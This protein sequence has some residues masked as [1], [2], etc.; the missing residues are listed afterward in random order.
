MQVAGYEDLVE[1]GRG[2]SAVVYRAR[3]VALDRTVALKVLAGTLGDDERRRFRRECT[4]IAALGWHPRVVAV[5]DA[6]VSDE[7]HPWMA[8]EYLPGGSLA[9]RVK[10]EGPLSA[11]EVAAI[12]I[13]AADALDA[14]HR[15]RIVHRDVKPGN[16]LQGHV[17]DV[18]LADFGIAALDSTNTSVTASFGGTLA[19]MAPELFAGERATTASD[20]YAL[21]ATLFVL[22]SGRPPFLAETPMAIL[23]HVAHDPVPD[24]RPLGV[25]APLAA[26]VEQAMAKDPADRPPSAA[27]TV[28]ALQA[29]A[30]EQGWPVEPTYTDRGS[31]PTQPTQP[32]QTADPRS[33]ALTGARRF[34]EPTGQGDQPTVLRASA[35]DPPAAHAEGPSPTGASEGSP[36]RRGRRIAAAAVAAILIVVGIAAAAITWL[37]STGTFVAFEGDQVAIYGGRPDGLLWVEPELLETTDV[38]R[39]DLPVDVR[40]VI[41]ASKSFSSRSAATRFVVTLQSIADEASSTSTPAPAPGT[42]STTSIDPL[43]VDVP[44]VLLNGGASTASFEQFA[45]FFEATSSELETGEAPTRAETTIYASTEFEDDAVALAEMLG[46]NPERVKPLT[47]EVEADLGRSGPVILVVGRDAPPP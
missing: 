45:T 13:Q 18:K 10:D 24:L 21:G 36:S 40:R 11:I 20:L 8:M 31:Q 43:Q 16:L 28:A 32:A 4:A 19:F 7:G 1:I 42:A 39:S 26:V 35:P 12:G 5:H 37:G 29:V 25:P 2:A 23:G 17:G 34:D 47:P 33:T 9:R 44:L 15:Q 46:L 3:H 22:L 41:E 30:Q 38:A 14:A 6:G 27:A